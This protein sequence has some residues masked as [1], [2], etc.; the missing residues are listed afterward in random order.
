MDN[1][2][3]PATG[4]LR[5]K[6]FLLC[7]L[8]VITASV[9]FAIIGI[10]QLRASARVAAETNASQNEA[11]KLRSEETIIDLTFEDML[12]TITLAAKSADGEF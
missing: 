3:L 11:V 9:A 8:L 6:L 10:L 4:G 5:R 1:N 12:N 2:R 7:S